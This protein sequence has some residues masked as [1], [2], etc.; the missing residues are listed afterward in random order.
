[1]GCFF[2]DN[3]NDKYELGVNLLLVRGS[4]LKGIFIE[5]FTATKTK[6]AYFGAFTCL[7]PLRY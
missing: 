1:M 3:Y 6:Y 4:N 7:L 5:M 2:C